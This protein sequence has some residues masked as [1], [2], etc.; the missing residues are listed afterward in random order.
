MDTPSQTLAAKIM[1]RLVTEGLVTA[2]AAKKLQ[3][4]LADGKLGAGDWR[5]PIE[6]AGKKEAKP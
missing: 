3:P 5:L 4:Q 1:E 2:A 6:L